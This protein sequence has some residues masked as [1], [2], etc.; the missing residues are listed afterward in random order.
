MTECWLPVEQVVL[1]KG[2]EAR[3]VDLRVE[4]AARVVVV[5]VLA[6]HNRPE[7]TVELIV[8]VDAPN[9]VVVALE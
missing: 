9:R 8:A 2:V 4:M 1:A 6:G 5:R 7:E 3:E